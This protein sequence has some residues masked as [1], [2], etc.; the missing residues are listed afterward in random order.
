MS[1]IET[2][3]RQNLMLQRNNLIYQTINNHEAQY[4]ML[5]QPSFMNNSISD[6]LELENVNNSIQLMAINA[7]LQALEQQNNTS[8]FNYF[9]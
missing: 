5:N 4:G 1:L 6:T 7:E 2:L 8:K 9:A 3:Y